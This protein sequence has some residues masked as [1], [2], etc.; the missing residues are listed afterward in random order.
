MLRN[1]KGKSKRQDVALYRGTE[2]NGVVRRKEYF[3]V[4]VRVVWS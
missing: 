3:E 2:L 1:V 4:T